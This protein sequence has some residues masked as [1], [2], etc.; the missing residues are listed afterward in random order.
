MMTVSS[1]GFVLTQAQA[2]RA[3]T[4]GHRYLHGER[5]GAGGKTDKQRDK[6]AGRQAGRQAD[7]HTHT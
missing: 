5:N 1:D 4:H 3:Q 7:T 6:Q 2:Q